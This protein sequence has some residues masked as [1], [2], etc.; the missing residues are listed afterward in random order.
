VEKGL[1]FFLGITN[2]HFWD[3]KNDDPGMLFVK[4]VVVKLEGPHMTFP[5]STKRYCAIFVIF[6]M[7]FTIPKISISD[8]RTDYLIKMLEKS[9]N[10]RLRV[11]AATTLGKLRIKQA[12]PSLVKATRDPN[13][14]VII[15]AAI[16]L[17]QIGDGSVLGELEKSVRVAPTKAAR[18]QLEV[19]VRLLKEIGNG[20]Q[21]VPAQK[22]APRFFVRVDAMGNS[23]TDRR[24]G[25]PEIMRKLVLE[26]VETEA[27]VIV[28]KGKMNS[29]AVERKIKAQKLRGYIISGSILRMEVV[30]E[31]LVVKL[32]L[33]LFSNP[34]YNLLMM[35]TA[36]ASIEVDSE[37]IN[38]KEGSGVYI[39]AVKIVADSLI[40]TIFSTLRQAETD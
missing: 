30:E 32:G 3:I 6:C 15:S 12:V 11:Q 26:R 18:S 39:R 19:T 40:D 13:E 14:L 28:Q 34:E 9:T 36:E 8:A 21:S 23:S 25:L 1:Q 35:P 7:I 20:G 24:E 29:E 37:I 17:K 16:A 2:D 4:V 33:N 5:K 10:Y 27:D 38:T 22:R 31:R